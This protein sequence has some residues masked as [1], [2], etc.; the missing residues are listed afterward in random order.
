MTLDALPQSL[1]HRLA[2][3][4]FHS[5]ADLATELGVSRTSVWKAVGAL[6]ALGLEV[7]ALPGKG[8]RLASPLE[9]LDAARI[10]AALSPEAAALLASLDIHAEIDSTNAQ[11]MRRAA[12]GAPSGSV[13]LAEAQSQGRG[14]IGRS[15]VS[16]FGSNVY[17][18]L[19]WRYDEPSRIG[20]LSLA[21]G[22]GVARALE[23]LGVV[24]VGLKWPNDLL[25][26]ERKLGGILIEVAGEAHGGCA[27]VIGIGLNRTLPP[28]AAQAIDQPWA[29][30]ALTEGGPPPRN[31]LAAALL[32]ELLPL[33]ADYAE[34]GLAPW[35]PE[36]RR[37][38]AL[39]G[40]EAT[41]LAGSM[42]VKGR[43]EDVS[44]AGLL[45][46]RCEDGRLREFASGEVSL[47]ATRTDA[48]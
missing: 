27:A 5:G 16:P 8:Y 34:R 43:I 6:G 2:D 17:L 25:L 38:H 42:Q 24:G 28:Q 46:L 19:L 26:E 44:E 31:L 14:R 41:L 39:A 21:A 29:D 15:W 1:L 11:L 18:S 37:R 3:Q 22:V 7:L 10:H 12:Q 35:L 47:R 20:G 30:L 40:R 23:G 36:W 48:P 9:L 4:R 45:V 33:L 13:C 32:N